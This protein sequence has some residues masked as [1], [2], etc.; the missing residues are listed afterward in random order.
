M[1]I[2]KRAKIHRESKCAIIILSKTH[3]ERKRWNDKRKTTIPYGHIF[4]G[5]SRFSQ[6]QNFVISLKIHRESKRL[7]FQTKNPLTLICCPRWKIQRS[8][9][10]PL[11]QKRKFRKNGKP[12]NC[13]NG[14]AKIRKCVIAGVLFKLRQACSSLAAVDYVFESSILNTQKSRLRSTQDKA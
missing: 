10:D 13:K 3:R 7:L 8:I 2:E 14:T 4:L 5:S 11:I 12:K 9:R 6:Q 1:R